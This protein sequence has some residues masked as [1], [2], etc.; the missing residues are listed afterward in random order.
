MIGWSAGT[1]QSST[2]S[3]LV[4]ARRWQSAHIWIP[5]TGTSAARSAS[6]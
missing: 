4:T 3:G 2:R 5:T 1:L 6:L